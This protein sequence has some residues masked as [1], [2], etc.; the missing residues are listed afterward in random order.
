MIVTAAQV[1]QCTGYQQKDT[2]QRP[3]G[4]S[5][6]VAIKT[7]T[8]LL[9]RPFPGAPCQ[10]GADWQHHHQVDPRV[11]SAGTRKPA[12]TSYLFSFGWENA[13]LGKLP[14]LSAV[15]VTDKVGLFP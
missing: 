1:N 15:E 8:A 4:G 9:E 10:A 6:A 13:F 14:V 3:Q 5:A 11:W 12:L 2:I 7:A